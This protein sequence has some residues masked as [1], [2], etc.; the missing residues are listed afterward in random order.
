MKNNKCLTI[1]EKIFFVLSAIFFF[2]STFLPVQAG[3]RS[4]DSFSS[5]SQITTTAYMNLLALYGGAFLLIAFLLGFAIV[6]FGDAKKYAIGSALYCAAPLAALIAFLSIVLNLSSS[7]SFKP[8]IGSIMLFIAIVLYIVSIVLHA[9][10]SLLI[11]DGEMNDV[12][13]RIALVRTYKEF[14]DEGVITEEE[15]QAKKDEILQ[16]KSKKEAKK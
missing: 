9:I 3:E 1:S 16:L 4:S 15:F 11:K 8:G 10:N 2:I 14:K 7:S 13:E 6:L 5:S 12:D